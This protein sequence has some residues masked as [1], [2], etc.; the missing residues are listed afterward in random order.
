MPK[1]DGKDDAIVGILLFDD[2]LLQEPI[3]RLAQAS[4]KPENQVGSRGP[5][6]IVQ[7]KCQESGDNIVERNNDSVFP[8]KNTVFKPPTN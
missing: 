1:R 7:Q 5:P 4:D 6:Q 8:D 2:K 3:D